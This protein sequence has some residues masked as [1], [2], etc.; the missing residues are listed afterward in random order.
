MADPLEQ[1]ADSLGCIL[2]RTLY[3]EHREQESRQRELEELDA[4]AARTQHLAPTEG[5]ADARGDLRKV[6]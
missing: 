3:R 5:T 2:A 6:Q 1:L 4:V